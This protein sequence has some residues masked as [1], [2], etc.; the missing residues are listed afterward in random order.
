M[1]ETSGNWDSAS[2]VFENTDGNKIII[3]QNALSRPEK[4]TINY[5]TE[6]NTFLLEPESINT[7]VLP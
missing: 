3:V 5:N 1:L 4:I 2:A 6:E 7:F